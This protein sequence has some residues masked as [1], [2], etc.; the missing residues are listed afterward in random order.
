MLRENSTAIGFRRNSVVATLCVKSRSSSFPLSPFILDQSQPWLS[1][2]VTHSTS[3]LDSN[4]RTGFHAFSSSFYPLE[5][6]FKEE[7]SR[8]CRVFRH[9]SPSLAFIHLPSPL[10]SSSSFSSI[11]LS[12]IR[13][14]LGPYFSLLVF[15]WSSSFHRYFFLFFSFFRAHFLYRSPAR[16]AESPPPRALPISSLSCSIHPSIHPSSTFFSRVF[17]DIR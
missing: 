6:G 9:D 8:S 4:A 10:S 12:L 17:A 5:R 16:V 3:D 13:P 15:H 1:R 11:S 2:L 7:R 14:R